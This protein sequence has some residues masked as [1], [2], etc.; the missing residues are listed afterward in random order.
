VSDTV[1]MK[2]DIDEAR[3][4]LIGRDPDGNSWL[5]QEIKTRLPGR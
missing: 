5:R 4:V 3:E 1:D 2:H